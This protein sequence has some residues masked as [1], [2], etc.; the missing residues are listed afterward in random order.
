MAKKGKLIKGVSGNPKGRPQKSTSWKTLII[1]ALEETVTVREHGKP[2]QITVAE[3]VMKSFVKRCLDGD[4]AC[5]DL[6]LNGFG[7]AASN[8]PEVFRLQMGKDLSKKPLK[9]PD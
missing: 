7:N 4:P 3:L 8:A 1:E 6:L 5:I 9:S 2:A